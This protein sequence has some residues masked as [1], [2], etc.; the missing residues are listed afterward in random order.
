MNSVA[1]NSIWT[2]RGAILYVVVWAISFFCAMTYTA[3]N[4]P[5][6]NKFRTNAGLWELLVIAFTTALWFVV[7]ILLLSGWVFFAI[8]IVLYYVWCIITY[9][10]GDYAVMQP[11]YRLHERINRPVVTKTFI[12]PD[13]FKLTPIQEEVTEESSNKRKKH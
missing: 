5:T 4:N 8:C 7:W 1:A 11:L 9:L 12:I 10:I 13:G 2:E 6:I 3:I